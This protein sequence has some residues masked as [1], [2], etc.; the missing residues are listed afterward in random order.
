MNR[1]KNELNARTLYKSIKSKT[2]ITISM[3]NQNE[4][5][6]FNILRFATCDENENYVELQGKCVNEI[7]LRK[8]LFKRYDTILLT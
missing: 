8:N 5:S 2:G 3:M 6:N 7:L 4:F 1:E